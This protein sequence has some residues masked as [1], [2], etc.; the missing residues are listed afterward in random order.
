MNTTV[1]LPGVA[2]KALALAA[3]AAEDRADMHLSEGRLI[4]AGMARLG[5]DRLWLQAMAPL[6][7][8]GDEYGRRRL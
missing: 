4:A 1:E 2:H 3:I 5:A 7:N 6:G 8:E